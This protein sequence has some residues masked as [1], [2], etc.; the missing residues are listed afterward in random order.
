MSPMRM[1]KVE[2]AIRI[3]LEY[4]EAFNRRAVDDMM[5]LLSEDCVYEHHSPA[6]DGSTYSGKLAI[7]RF[8]LAFFRES[9]NAE[10]K[11]EDVF[12]LGYRCIMRWKYKWVDN[13]GN[14]TYTRGVDIFLV[15]DNFI[16]E[17]L[18]YLKA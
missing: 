17:I 13:Y 4:N 15:K 8:W 5:R 10:V 3:V 18:S 2:S 9:P 7:S 11:I 6:P 1:S 12:G 14:D 16:C